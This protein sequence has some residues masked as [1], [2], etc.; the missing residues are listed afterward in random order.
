MWWSSDLVGVGGM[1]GEHILIM[2]R[3]IV[4]F[5]GNEKAPPLT[6]TYSCVQTIFIIFSCSKHEFS[7]Q[8]YNDIGTVPAPKTY[9]VAS[10]N[11]REQ[12]KVGN[13]Q[14]WSKSPVTP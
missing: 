8:G 2:I 6:Y 14:E 5:G 7:G 4:S 13:G 9:G 10:Y 12:G 1:L 11:T 3:T